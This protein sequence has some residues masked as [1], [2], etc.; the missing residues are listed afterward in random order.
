MGKLISFKRKTE[1]MERIAYRVDF[2]KLAIGDSIPSSSSYFE[3]SAE[4]PK[5]KEIEEIFEKH[6]PCGKPK[7]SD[8]KYVFEKQT[9]A[10]NFLFKFNRN[11]HLYEV[12]Y[13]E[14]DL[15]HEA[16]W[17]WLGRAKNESANIAECAKN[18]W[19]GVKGENAVVE[20]LVS[21]AKVIK[22]IEF[23]EKELRKARLKAWGLECLYAAKFTI[24]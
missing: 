8:A 6:R 13:C 9:D 23:T 15:L 3:K 19:D 11:S 1:S 10:E 17:N 22:H 12:S 20:F 2:S 14:K 18:Y 24:Q 7:R 16:D 4:D 21:K 5:R